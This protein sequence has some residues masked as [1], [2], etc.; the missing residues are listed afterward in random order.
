[1]NV[2]NYSTNFFIKIIENNFPISHDEA[3]EKVNC[4]QH[5][6]KTVQYFRSDKSV[7]DSIIREPN[8]GFIYA[9]KWPHNTVLVYID[10]YNTLNSSN[11]CR[12]LIQSNIIRNNF[13]HKRTYN[14]VPQ[15]NSKLS[16]SIYMEGY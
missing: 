3:T 6:T 9:T 8:K 11:E 10:T 7:S 12:R 13:I 2:I 1:M 5:V 16:R 15:C 14:D 4:I